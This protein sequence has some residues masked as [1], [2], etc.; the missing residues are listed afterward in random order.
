MR[1]E[2]ARQKER[3][4]IMF[5]YSFQV[6]EQKK[7]RMIVHTDCKNEAD[8]Q[9]AVAHHLMTPRFAVAGI[10][11]GHFDKA[12]MGRYPEGGTAQASYDEVMKV[13]D[14]MHVK[15]EYPVYMGSARALQDEK[16]PI[17]CPGAR[18][19]IEE[20]MKDDPRPLFI[21]MQ[22]AITDLASAI[23]ME[24]K[25]CERMTAIW[26]GGGVY[27]EGGFEFNLMQDV[28]AANVVM[29][30]SMPLW[31]V[32]MNVYKQ[33]SVTLAEL[34]LKVKPY[35]EIG[36]Y[37]FTQ[38]AE[39]NLKLADF[40][41]WPHGEI[42]GLGDQATIAVLMEENEKTDIFEMVPAPCFD[43]ETMKYIHG[44]NNREIRVYHKLNDRLT[45]EDFFC[46]LQLNFPK[47]DS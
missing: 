27:P 4:D 14:L 42:W 43:V 22:G 41:T 25:I 21:A 34:E 6:P 39:L 19:I 20:A 32:P 47:R 16:T 33:M 23:L 12:N 17:D 36:N 8:D 7:I 5:E 2:E 1:V 18:F 24:P 30:S 29:K 46:K 37:L 40:P 35:G 9:Y 10:I 45:L 11:A 31:Q 15:D 13:L 28:H 26:I 44:Q 3:S 38:M